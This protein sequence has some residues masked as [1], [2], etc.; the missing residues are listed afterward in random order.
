[1]HGAWYTSINRRSVVS[2]IKMA[3]FFFFKGSEA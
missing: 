3:L 2:G 1:M